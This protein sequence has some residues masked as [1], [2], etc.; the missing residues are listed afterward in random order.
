MSQQEFFPQ[1]EY[2][3]DGSQVEAQQYQPRLFSPP[4]AKAGDLTKQEHP[5][6]YEEEELAP[7]PFSYPAQDLAATGRTRDEEAYTQSSSHSETASRRQYST[8]DQGTI[9]RGHR[10]Y[11]QYKSW[12][13]VPPWARAQRN[14]G[15]VWK[16]VVLVLLVFL[17][18]KLLPII[19]ALVGI[20]LLLILIPIFIV[21]GIVLTMVIILMVVLAALGIPVHR[22]LFRWWR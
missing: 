16:I 2:D 17:A 9:N 6:A 21:L 5:L 15:A 13:Q 19:L 10:P 3:R 20:G 1:S 22:R 18:I 8:A 11:S 4:K 7:P 14:R 12:Q